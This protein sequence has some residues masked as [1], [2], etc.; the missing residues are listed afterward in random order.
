MHEPH[1]CPNHKVCPH[2][3]CRPQCTCLYK[4]KQARGLS[5]ICRGRTPCLTSEVRPFLC[6]FLHSNCFSAY[7]PGSYSKLVITPQSGQDFSVFVLS[8]D[9][10]SLDLSG[11]AVS[12]ILLVVCLSPTFLSRGQ[13]MT[14]LMRS[15]DFDFQS[16]Y[17][18]NEGLDRLS[19][20]ASL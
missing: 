10:S 18:F 4:L 7:Q 14:L 9:S 17:N 6:L 1:F 3:L 16:F 19:G 13:S 20:I 8:L 15:A 2:C 12:R 11:C 5:Y